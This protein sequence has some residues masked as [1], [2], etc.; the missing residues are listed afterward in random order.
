M[1]SFPTALRCC[2]LAL[3]LPA[4]A[5]SDAIQDGTQEETRGSAQDAPLEA[6]RALANHRRFLARSPYHGA[7]FEQLLQRLTLSGA[8]DALV[9]EY[10]D[11]HA[12]HPAERPTTV[13][14]ARLRGA[15][16]EAGRALELIAELASGG[17]EEG[18]DARL[19]F[20]RAQF[21]LLD[22]QRAAAIRVLGEAADTSEPGAFRQEVLELRAGAQLAA[23][24]RDGARESLLRLAAGASDHEDRMRA[25]GRLSRSGF[26]ESAAAEFR[27]A[28]QA[29]PDPQY[30]SE[31]LAALGRELE[32]L[33][34]AE[35]AGQVYLEALTLLA[36]DHWLARDLRT[37]IL[38]LH[39]RGG[40]LPE[41][42]RRYR[43]AL[44]ERPT[45]RGLHAALAGALER[46]GLRDPALEV[47]AAAVER[48]PDDLALSRA[49]LGTARRARA[50]DQ[51]IAEY[52]RLL[53]RRPADAELR[54]ELGEEFAAGGHPEQAAEQWSQL[55]AGRPHDPDLTRRVAQRWTVHG[56][57]E[58]ARELFERA[59]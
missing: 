2:F 8:L 5:S 25:A 40:R 43:R 47:L 19:F 32:R 27:I 57:L 37:R 39:E 50:T 23:G 36:H 54:F 33:A 22:G 34:R 38:V 1:S 59:L 17:E 51:L 45:D 26:S 9:A 56:R 52:Q 7:V 28:A 48:F 29:D 14:L 4:P 6:D 55:L 49:R 11:E 42:V 31:A 24:D 20:L 10:E 15:Q 16:G 3:L 58:R 21:L 18:G 44:T 35:D 41:L 12:A 13:V 53:A 30:R 46:S